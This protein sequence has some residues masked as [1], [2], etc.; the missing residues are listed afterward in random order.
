MP[1][2]RVNPD[3]LRNV[4]SQLESGA[5]ELTGLLDR[6]IAQVNNLNGQW[7]GMAQVQYND[8]FQQEVPQMKTKTDEILT[9]LAQMLRKAAEV[10]EQADQ[11]AV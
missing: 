1:N 3:E 6:L 10:L 11:N 4:A 5:S 2:I 7:E 9:N 8:R